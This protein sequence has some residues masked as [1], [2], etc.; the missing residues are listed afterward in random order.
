MAAPLIQADDPAESDAI[1]TS[2][3]VRRPP[4]TFWIAL[5]LGWAMIAFGLRGLLHTGREVD[6]V[7]LARLFAVAAIVH[8]LIL[9]PAVIAV[10]VAVSRLVPR[11]ARPFV[12]AG[13]IISGCVAL[14]S[15]PFVG[16]WGRQPDNPTVLPRSYATGLVAVLVVVWLGVA[17][18]G[19][20]VTWQRRRRGEP[21]AR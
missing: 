2:N 8:D 17:V 14:F 19:A 13:L 4:V 5:A 7:G 11:G 3:E 9:A 20:V 10:G 18:A 6:K 21:N 15:Y 16:G 1:T 12:Q